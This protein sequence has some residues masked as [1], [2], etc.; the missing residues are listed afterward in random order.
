MPPVQENPL[1]K[2]YFTLARDNPSQPTPSA[3][4]S[5]SGPKAE[6]GSPVNSVKPLYVKTP[7]PDIT[8]GYRKEVMIPALAKSGKLSERYVTLFLK[9]GQKNGAWPSVPT[10]NDTEVRFPF[11]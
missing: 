9:F 4:G 3:L 5:N 8:I 6:P 11:L 2:N 7:S 10:Q 1:D